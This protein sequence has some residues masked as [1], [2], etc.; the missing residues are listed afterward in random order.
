M[1]SILHVL[2]L[3]T[4]NRVRTDPGKSWNLKFKFSM[5]GKSWKVVENKPNDCHISDPCTRMFLAFT[6]IIIV[7]CQTWF[8]LLFSII[9]NCVT[10]SVLY[11]NLTRSISTRLNSPVKTWKMDKNDPEKSWKMHI[12][13]PENSWKTTFNVL[14]APCKN[15]VLFSVSS[16]NFS[17]SSF[18][19]EN[20]SSV[21]MNTQFFLYIFTSCRRFTS[22]A[23]IWMLIII[24]SAI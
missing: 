2:F 17:G 22:C 15:A 14:Y 5:P 8:D 16:K 11:E 24:M 6:Y 13:S 7:H 3:I 1:S 23:F 10:Y 18:M 20:V 21:C 19:A 9:M 4:K 12:K